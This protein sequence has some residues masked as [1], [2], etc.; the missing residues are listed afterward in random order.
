MRLRTVGSSSKA[1]PS[2]AEAESE[3]VRRASAAFSNPQSS[4]GMSPQ[5]T[6]PTTI[7]PATHN[8]I[9][10]LHFLMMTLPR[11]AATHGDAHHPQSSF[12]GLFSLSAARRKRRPHSRH[13]PGRLDH[14]Q[15]KTE[16]TICWTCG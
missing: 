15:K 7:H 13:I 3:D 14:D 4:I 1:Q 2:A 10:S 12:V 8:S 11:N 9:A 16:R 6:N 5:P